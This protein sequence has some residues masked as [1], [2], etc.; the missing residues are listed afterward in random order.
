MDDSDK[1]I[2]KC[3]TAF[4]VTLVLTIGSCTTYQNKVIS[5]ADDPVAAACAMGSSSYACVAIGKKQP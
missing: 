4:F 1:L 5:E 3:V 2:V